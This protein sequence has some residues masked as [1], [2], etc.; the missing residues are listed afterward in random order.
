MSKALDEWRD[1]RRERLDR[2]GVAHGIVRAARVPLNTEYLNWSLLLTLTSE[3]HGFTRDLHDLAVR[4][5]VRAAAPGNARLAAV[6]SARLTE[7]RQ[8][9]KGNPNPDALTADF[10]RLGLPLWDSLGSGAEAWRTA[11]ATMLTARNAVA[12]ADMPRLRAVR[13]QGTTLSVKTIK[14]W[15]ADLD[16]L[17]GAL[18]AAVAA[19]HADLFATDRPW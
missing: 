8:L 1:A 16:A 18:D 7:G 14:G 6:L 4:T 17:A 19:H 12:H 13:A 11:L 9:A 15:R 5:F 10:G 2:L 3:F